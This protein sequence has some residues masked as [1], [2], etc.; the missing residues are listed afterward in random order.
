MCMIFA[1]KTYSRIPLSASPNKKFLINF[2]TPNFIL[3][4]PS[5]IYFD[6]T[7]ATT[8]DPSISFFKKDK[9]KINTCSPITFHIC[10]TKC[11]KKCKET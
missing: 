7:V 1:P 10:N 4:V 6:T 5:T 11:S 9:R 2:P 8:T 3:K